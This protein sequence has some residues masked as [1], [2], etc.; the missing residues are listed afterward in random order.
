MK[1]TEAEREKI[2]ESLAE[3]KGKYSPSSSWV[4]VFDNLAEFAGGRGC[5]VLESKALAET[6]GAWGCILPNLKRIYIQ[7]RNITRMVPTLAHEVG[8]LIAY[9]AGIWGKYDFEED[10]ADALGEAL[11]EML[12][13]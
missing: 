11:L 6:Q 4:V 1:I 8:H 10:L 12:M 7:T 5:K 13:V 3:I 9:K 2:I